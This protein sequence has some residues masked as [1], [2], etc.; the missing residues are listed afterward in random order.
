MSLKR[1]VASGLAA[2]ALTGTSFFLLSGCGTTSTPEQVAVNSS[3]PAT[4]HSNADQ[5]TVVPLTV[6]T[7]TFTAG[8]WGAGIIVEA[9]G[10]T[11]NQPITVTL[12]EDQGPGKPQPSDEY[13]TNADASG[14]L[15][16]VWVPSMVTVAPDAAGYPFYAVSAEQ[17]GEPN[18]PTVVTTAVKLTITP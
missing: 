12:T 8:N 17:S 16:A 11:P 14:N 6:P 3:S 4:G 10:F 5:V 9:S 7:T 13:R 18:V 1:R 2:I 15:S